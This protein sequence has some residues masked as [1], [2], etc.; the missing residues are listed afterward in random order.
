MFI[1]HNT[2]QKF[3]SRI[4]ITILL[5][6]IQLLYSTTVSAVATKEAVVIS[7]ESSVSNVSGISPTPSTN[8]ILNYSLNI[9]AQSA[10]VVE[11]GRGM[12]LYL[13]NP[14]LKSKIPAASKIMVAV[15]ALEAIPLDTKITVSKVAASQSDANVLAL[16]NG[17]K[18]SL[19]YLLYGMLLKDN[20]AA[21]VAISEQISGEES[22]FVKLMNNKA[23]SY[24]MNNTIFTNV[25][26]KSDEAQYSTVGDVARLVRFALTFPKFEIILKTK[27]IPFFLST[28]QTKHLI[29]NLEQAW[30]LVDTTTGAIQCNSDGQSSFVTTSYSGGINIITVACTTEKSKTINDV[31]VISNS[32]FTDYEFSNL[33]MEN[34]TFPKSLVIGTDTIE[35]IF[36]QAITYVHPKDVEFI[37]S[38]TYEENSIVEY[39]ILTTKTVGKVIFELLDGTKIT[40]DLYPSRAVWGESNF[41]QKIISVYSA[42]R[43][44]GILVIISLGFLLLL[45]VYHLIRLIIKLFAFIFKSSKKRRMHNVSENNSIK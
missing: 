34:Q 40:A 3:Y 31:T 12:R 16:N 8:P 10:I 20:N 24:Q 5:I 43:D 9:S 6:S 27:D 35:L 36:K 17:E 2:C 13:K 23:I 45:C 26:G 32:I 1:P 28:N 15:I 42:N 14:D 41:Y 37:N 38:T 4:I 19:E 25:T 39:P 7:Q 11:I 22:A 33:A 29:N 21:A 30:S 18:Y 44:I